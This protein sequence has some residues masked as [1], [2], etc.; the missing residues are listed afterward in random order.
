MIDL[1]DLA[2]DIPVPVCFGLKTKRMPGFIR[3]DEIYIFRLQETVLISID[4]PGMEGEG[5]II[6]I[7][8]ILHIPGMKRVAVAE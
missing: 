6:A 4:E 8:S 1:P 2:N 3:C 7:L 5:Q